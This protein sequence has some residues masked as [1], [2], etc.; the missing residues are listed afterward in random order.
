MKMYLIIME[1]SC[2]GID[3]DDSIC[4]G[5]YIIKI[6]SSTYTL[7]E[8]LSIDGQFISF[9]EML[10]EGTY[11]FPI[12]TNYRYYVLQKIQLHYCISK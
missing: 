12:N 10:C 1:G 9:V 6:S 8:D 7:Q 5:Y 11:F 4:H 2:G 3:A